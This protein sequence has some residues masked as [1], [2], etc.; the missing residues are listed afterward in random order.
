MISSEVRGEFAVVDLLHP[1][2]GRA[3]RLGGDLFLIDAELV[4]LLICPFGALPGGLRVLLRGVLAGGGHVVSCEVLLD[5]RHGDIAGYVGEELVR[6]W[7]LLLLFLLALGIGRDIVI[8]DFGLARLGVLLRI[9]RVLVLALVK[10]LLLLVL[11]LLLVL[12]LLSLLLREP[13]LM[14]ARLVLVPGALFGLGAPRVLLLLPGLLPQRRLVLLVLALARPVG[15]TGRRTRHRTVR[16]AGTAHHKIRV[17]ESFLLG[18]LIGSVLLHLIV[19]VVLR[20]IAISVVIC[21]LIVGILLLVII[22]L[23]VAIVILLL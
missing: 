2:P 23:L 16:F 1:V 21:V 8:V 10:V 11:R 3:A 15:Q 18:C 4:C 14:L 19:R 6:L 9:P 17:A 22:L 5:G 13:F 12:L 7:P 20:V